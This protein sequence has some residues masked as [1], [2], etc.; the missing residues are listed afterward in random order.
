MAKKLKICKG[1][2][3]LFPDYKYLQMQYLNSHVMRLHTFTNLVSAASSI[4]YLIGFKFNLQVPLFTSTDE[5]VQMV[6][7]HIV[8][9]ITT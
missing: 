7:L 8:L 2:P 3:I 9:S 4:R 6:D 1:K 5:H